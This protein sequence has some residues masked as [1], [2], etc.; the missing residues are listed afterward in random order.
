MA[1]LFPAYFGAPY[2]PDL[3]G[4]GRAIDRICGCPFWTLLRA[5]TVQKKLLGRLFNNEGLL[6]SMMLMSELYLLSFWARKVIPCNWYY[7]AILRP[8]IQAMKREVT[9]KLSVG[10]HGHIIARIDQ[11]LEDGEF[12]HLVWSETGS[13]ARNQKKVSTHKDRSENILARDAW[14]RA[15]GLEGDVKGVHQCFGRAY[16]VH[17]TTSKSTDM[18]HGDL[19]DHATHEG[20]HNYTTAR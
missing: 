5:I 12:I 1:S 16:S 11:C 3:L 10:W 15:A 14:S 19:V 18:S 7:F 6:E 4:S 17:L 20:V 8:D 2:N 13:N 9:C